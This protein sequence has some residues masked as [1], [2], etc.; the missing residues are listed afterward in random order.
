MILAEITTRRSADLNTALWEKYPNC[1][2]VYPPWIGN[3]IC[4]GDNLDTE[5]CRFDDGDCVEFNEQFNE[6]SRNC[7]ADCPE[8]IGNGECDGE[9]YNTAECA[10][11]TLIF[12]RPNVET[13]TVAH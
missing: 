7:N 11:M 10:T 9:D 5:E 1:F 4:D 3:G 2:G 12:L 6:L 13:K 8:D